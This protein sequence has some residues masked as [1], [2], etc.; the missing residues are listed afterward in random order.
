MPH[1]L[2]LR[3]EEVGMATANVVRADKSVSQAPARTARPCSATASRL[4][5]R[6]GVRKDKGM[7]AQLLRSN[8]RS[9][10]DPTRSRNQRTARQS[11]LRRRAGANAATLE[12]GSEG[13]HE[14]Q[15]EVPAR[16]RRDLNR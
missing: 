10:H 4:A 3:C 7:P 12:T 14:A 8:A 5:G 1:S 15:P 2:R 6:A 11:A 13:E 16:Q 9:G